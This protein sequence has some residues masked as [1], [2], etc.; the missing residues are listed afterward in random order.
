MAIAP[1]FAPEPDGG[2]GTLPDLFATLDDDIAGMDPTFQDFAKLSAQYGIPMAAYEGGQ[3][4][5]GTTDQP[6]LHLAQHD[7]RM[8]AAYT[9]YF[10]LWNKDF[11]RSLFMHFSLAGIPGLPE[12]IYQCG[13]HRPSSRLAGS[14]A[15]QKATAACRSERRSFVFKVEREPMRILMLTMTR[16]DSGPRGPRLAGTG[17]IDSCRCGSCGRS[18]TED[19]WRALPLAQTLDPVAIARH[20]VRW[21]PQRS[22]EIRRC[23]GCAGSI[24]RTTRG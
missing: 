4:L 17:P 9:Q 24:A 16:A 2:T 11:G 19:E 14:S 23:G 15:E 1:Y 21:R 6:I 5:T 22:I 18:F 13:A 10:A 8:Y 20:V 3:S 12:N 7:A